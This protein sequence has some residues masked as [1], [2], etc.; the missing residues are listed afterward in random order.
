[1]SSSSSSSL[2]SGISH[3]GLAVSDLEA[4][5]LFFEALGYKKVGGDESYP[6]YFISNDKSILTLWQ[7]DANA[8]CF[9]RKINVGLHH[10]ALQVNSEEALHDAYNAVL[11]VPGTTNEFGPKDFPFGKHA[12]VHDPSGLRIEFSLHL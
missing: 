6:S 11:K 3:I 8:V 10:L 9:N 7:T 4:S 12:M 2:C 1:M 5:F